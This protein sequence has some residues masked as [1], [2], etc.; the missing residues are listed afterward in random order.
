[1][2]LQIP[3]SDSA[4]PCIPSNSRIMSVIYGKYGVGEMA[5]LVAFKFQEVNILWCSWE[6]AARSRDSSSNCLNFDDD[7]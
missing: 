4:P 3:F 1:M 5:E 2:L 6:G 7:L